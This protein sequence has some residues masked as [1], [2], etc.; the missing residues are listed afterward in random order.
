MKA[1]Y[2]SNLILETDCSIS[3]HMEILIVLNFNIF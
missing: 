1:R 3:N 2:I